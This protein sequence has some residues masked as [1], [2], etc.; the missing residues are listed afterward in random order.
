M[1]VKIISSGGKLERVVSLSHPID[2]AL[3][4][5]GKEAMVTISGDKLAKAGLK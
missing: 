3:S 4:E 1:S 2:V 5:N